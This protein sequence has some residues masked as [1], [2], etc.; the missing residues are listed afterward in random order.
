MADEKIAAELESLKITPNGHG[1][2]KD[3]SRSS[4]NKERLAS[5]GN[6]NSSSSVQ[7]QKNRTKSVSTGTETT[8]SNHEHKRTSSVMESNQPRVQAMVKVGPNEWSCRFCTFLNPNAKKICE[9]CS[10]SKD[11]FLDADKNSGA[12]AATTCV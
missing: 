3:R 10:K 1:P 11:F 5:V 9:M 12:A 7:V 4:S 8:M 6:S 2:P